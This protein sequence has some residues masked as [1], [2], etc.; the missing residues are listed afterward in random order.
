LTTRSEL[1]GRDRILAAAAE[2]FAAHG[3]DRTAT[4]RI[5][6]AA[7]VPHGLIFYHFKTKMDLLLA[8]VR[9]DPVT[10]P[11]ELFPPVPP[12]TDLATA[13]AGVWRGL[14]AALGEPSTARRILIQ[15]MAVH[16]EVRQRAREYHERLA[17]VIAARLAGAGPAP[18]AP[19]PEHEAAARLLTLA[20]GLAPLLGEPAGEL[21]PAGPLAALISGGLLAAG[22]AG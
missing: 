17:G 15:E 1:G 20:A 10:E 9:D 22:G 14:G 2:L 19:G 21:I 3:Y 8:V 18:G 6:A 11:G 16:P 13:V 4:A 12:G 5:A 7:R